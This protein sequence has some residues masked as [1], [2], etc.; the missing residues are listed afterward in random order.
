M[1][2][3]LFNIVDG[4]PVIEAA[5]VNLTAFRKLWDKDSSDDKS[6]YKQWM[7]Y[8]YYMYDYESEFYELS[9]KEEKV[10]EEVFNKKKVSIPKEIEDC[11]KEYRSKNVPVEQRTLD[12]AIATADSVTSSIN[13]LQRSADQMDDVIA[14]LD[15]EIKNALKA[16]ES[17]VAVELT[18]EKL[19]IQKQL[20]DIT[21]KSSSLIPKIEK[22]VNSIIT[23]RASVEKAVA[24]DK[25][26]NTRIENYL[27]DDLII[28]KEVTQK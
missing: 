13:K 10:C 22:S 23:L 1:R 21:D 12:A 28:A 2:K 27:I 20:L 3:R 16:G 14:A 26:N 11:I 9:D 15:K 8:I 7:L 6:L 18:K 25:S 24:N 19:T 4:E 5:L 17:M